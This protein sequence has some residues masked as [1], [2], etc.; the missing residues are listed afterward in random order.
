MVAFDTVAR[1]GILTLMTHSNWLM[2]CYD[3]VKTADESSGFHMFTLP[4]GISIIQTKINSV[5]RPFIIN[6]LRLRLSMLF[7]KVQIEASNVSHYQK[8]RKII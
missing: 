7:P 1:D 6:L 8:M 2:R 4:F 5:F 3:Q